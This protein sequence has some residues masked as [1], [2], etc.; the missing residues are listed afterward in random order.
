MPAVVGKTGAVTLK[1][2]RG[3]AKTLLAFDIETDAARSRLAGFT[4][5]VKPP[6]KDAYY[7]LNDL[8]FATPG[9]HAQDPQEPAFSTLNAPIHKFR[10]VHVLGQ[11]HQGLKPAHGIYTYTVTPRYFDAKS[12]MLPLDPTASVSVDIEVDEF[13]SGSLKLGFTRGF[14]Q[15][16]AF[17]RHFG[18]DAQIKPHD[19]P[20]QFDTSQVS[21][22]NAEG[23]KFTYQDQYQWLGYTARKRIFEILDA[24]EADAGLQLD[25]FAYD[26][27]E[28]D[29]ITR[30]IA[31]GAKGQVRVILD[32]AALH[33]APAKPKPEDQFE[34]L[35]TAQAGA[36][37]LKRGHFSRYAHDKVLIVSDAA[38]PRRVLTGS[39]NFSVTGLYVNANHVL[40]FDDPAVAKV[41]AEVFSEAWNDDVHT[42][43]FAKSAWAKQPYA[44]GGAMTPDTSITFS[45]HEAAY[46]SQILGDM[47]T[48]INAEGSVEDRIGSVLFAVMEL[49]GGPNNPVYQALDALHADQS[50]F[51]YGIS[52]NPDG[53]S[54]YPLGSEEGVLVTGKPV[55][56]VLPPPFS[57]VPTVSE[58]GAGHQVHHKF[59]VCGFNSPDAVV[60]CGSSN[61]ALKGE[62]VNG[63]NLLAIR[64]QDV[65]AAFAIEALALVDHFDFLD[66][67]APKTAVKTTPAPALKSQAAVSAGWFLGTTDAWAHKYFD[68]QDLHSLDR[69][70]F[71][72]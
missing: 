46:A 48:R 41:Y 30:L 71:A 13:A 45:P 15:S 54:L 65:A 57:Q 25:V 44:V 72:G 62:E 35:F 7:I 66:R 55:G 43:A 9:D 1:A 42:A 50:L 64:D 47:V 24:V 2:Y 56:T 12:S 16:Q 18:K 26:L 60:Y 38:G 20:L 21:G 5:K 31:L 3:D 68:P 19:A 39:T 59:V 40:V 33:H 51:S 14:V 52:D 4:I 8:R 29:F 70:L 36:G 32:N 6:G 11:V 10:W 23:D 28:P 22:A 53:V 58:L 34:A 69:Q 61:L 67:M 27:N 17:V 37:K 49:D 63:D